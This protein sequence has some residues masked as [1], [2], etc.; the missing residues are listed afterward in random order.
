MPP[1]YMQKGGNGQSGNK[2]NVLYQVAER[3]FK[4]TSKVAPVKRSKQ[5]N[6]HYLDHSP[7]DKNYR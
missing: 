4:T 3:S 1:D 2:I 6:V 7:C 5:D